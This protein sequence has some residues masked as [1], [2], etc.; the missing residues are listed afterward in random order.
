MAIWNDG[1]QNGRRIRKMV[2]VTFL[3]L[4]GSGYR[5][6][7]IDIVVTFVLLSLYLCIVVVSLVSSTIFV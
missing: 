1:F 5:R 2:Y 3:S 4:L 7:R 6:G